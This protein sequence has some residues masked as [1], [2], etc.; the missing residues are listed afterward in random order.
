MK[1]SN[2]WKV[3]LISAAVAA[4]P[5]TAQAMPTDIEEAVTS[6][7]Y[8]AYAIQNTYEYDDEDLISIG[9]NYVAT[10]EAM[11]R[12][13]PFGDIE[14]STVP[15][16]TY[17]V[18]GECDD[19]MWYKVSGSITGYVYSMYLVPESDYNTS[20]GTNSDLN[21]YNVKE[22]DLMMRVTNTPSVNVR[23]APTTNSSVVAVLSEGE[24]IQVTGNV[25]TA[26]WYQCEYNG[27]T[28]YVC[29]DYLTPDFPQTMACQAQ[30]LNIRSAASAN[31]SVIGV[32]HYGDKIKASEL[33]GDWIKFSTDDGTIGYVND[34]YL[35][36]VE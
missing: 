6:G 18:V 4:M 33:D 16:Q 10:A 8:N 30:V 5:L 22:L 13:A 21:N 3:M 29:D 36:V 19:C 31:A 9:A 15:G 25:L 7:D 23:T 28:V 1:K 34:E 11:I 2:L 27:Q 32:L 12:T 17:Y 14:G 35:S 24:D 20:T 26:E